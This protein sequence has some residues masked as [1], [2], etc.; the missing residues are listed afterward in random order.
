MLAV[1]DR[2]GSMEAFVRVVDAGGFAPAARALRLSPAMVGKHVRSL[3]AR[4]GSR[5]LHRTTRSVALTDAG[6]EFYERCRVIL[7]EV[8]EAERGAVA[9]Q[10]HP[11]G[12]LRVAAPA[13]FK[14]LRLAAAFTGFARAFPE[15]ELE[16]SCDDRVVDLVQGGFDVAVRLGRLPD[17]SLIARK[18]A[19][20]HIVVCG[21]PAYLDRVGTP[22]LLS[23]LA[24]HRCLGYAYQ[25]SGEGWAFAAE[26]E[27]DLVVRLSGPAHR[28]NSAAVLRSLALAG[29]GLTQLPTFV[30]GEDLAAGR[31]VEVLAAHRP[32]GRWVHVVY[33][34][35]RHLPAAVRAFVDFLAGHLAP[36][37]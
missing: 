24:R 35:G 2:F 16:I 21:A 9:R 27:R 6:R 36:L 25:W 32:R 4:L 30:V 7:R 37:R 29:E 13:V 11:A 33:P 34:P 22:E 17:S 31:L 20:V 1:M 15:V 12:L 10:Q 19:P 8:D 28:S 14:D 3:E 5:L 23:D 26:D 18:L